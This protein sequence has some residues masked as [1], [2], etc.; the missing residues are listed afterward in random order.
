MD[1]GA[2]TSVRHAS[3]ASSSN[4][5]SSCA[6]RPVSW[7]G[8][9]KE[10]ARVDW[11]GAASRKSPGFPAFPPAP[12]KKTTITTGRPQQ[13][14][15]AGPCVRDYSYGPSLALVLWCAG[16]S[17]RAGRGSILVIQ[18]HDASPPRPA[19]G[20]RVRDCSY[21][22][23]VGRHPRGQPPMPSSRLSH[24]YE[25]VR[26]CPLRRGRR[27]RSRFCLLTLSSRHTELENLAR[28]TSSLPL[29]S[30]SRAGSRTTPRGRPSTIDPGLVC[31]S[32][33]SPSPPAYARAPSKRAGRL[34]VL[35][36]L[37][38]PLPLL[39]L[40]SAPC[41]SFQVASRLLSATASCMAIYA[42]HCCLAGQGAALPWGGTERTDSEQSTPLQITGA[43]K[44]PPR[45]SGVYFI[46]M[47]VAPRSC[48]AV[49]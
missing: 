22:V 35:V 37:E 39:R 5:V 33:R 17:S 36:A 30:V 21:A 40:A 9:G 28:R 27:N 15:A 38:G 14:R 10:T 2:P 11:C 7:R 6:R 1:A 26:V 48:L 23:D 20:R 4:E 29:L 47:L 32:G 42:C 13:L 34:L 45:T 43:P 12:A 8:P 19:L 44:L 41:P 46:R 3:F 49:M 16:K 31:W 18:C 25:H 24:R